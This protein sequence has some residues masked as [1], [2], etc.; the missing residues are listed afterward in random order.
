MEIMDILE[1]DYG[2]SKA[3]AIAIAYC[4][5]NVQYTRYLTALLAGE[6]I[7]AGN[8]DGVGGSLNLPESGADDIL[9]AEEELPDQNFAD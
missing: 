9:P 6:S 5:S 3:D 2:L 1:E 4:E 7:S 8:G